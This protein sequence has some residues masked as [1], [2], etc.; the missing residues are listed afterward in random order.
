MVE[1]S[2]GLDHLHSLAEVAF[3]LID[4]DLTL[5]A[6]DNALGYRACIFSIVRRTDRDD[7]LTYAKRIRIADRKLRDSE[8]VYFDNGNVGKLV[9]VDK[10]GFK[11]SAVGADNG[12]LLDT[13][14]YV[15]VCNDL[16]VICIYESRAEAEV[17]IDGHDA[18]LDAVYKIGK[19][20]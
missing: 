3:I 8:V 1:G 6:R 10:L 5:D 9:A 16:S 14:E 12:D 7:V 4:A 19:I 11:L 2:I 15:E 13:V 17:G 20:R 18:V